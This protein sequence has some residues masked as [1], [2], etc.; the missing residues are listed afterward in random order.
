[1][2][3]NRRQQQ[4]IHYNKTACINHVIKAPKEENI[5]IINKWNITQLTSVDYLESHS[6]L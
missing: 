1:M 3:H 5:L 2:R 4:N 6:V